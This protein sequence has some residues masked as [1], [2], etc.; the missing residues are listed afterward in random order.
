MGNPILKRTNNFNTGDP[1]KLVKSSGIEAKGLNTT[2]LELVGAR[3]RIENLMKGDR[4]KHF[5]TVDIATFD[6]VL[7]S[8]QHGIDYL[9][10]AEETIT[11]FQKLYG[12]K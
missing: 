12:I 4:S 9:E 8:I 1:E 10:F 7:K 6:V 3:N 11:N 5:N 2:R